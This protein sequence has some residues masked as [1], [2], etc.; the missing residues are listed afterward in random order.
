VALE[1]TYDQP[2]NR[3]RNP[4][5]QYIEAL[6]ARLHRAEA[7]LKTVLPDIDLND[8]NLDLTTPQ[9]ILP[10]FK[11][12][13]TA[14]AV[15]ASNPA[16]AKTNASTESGDELL[17]SMVDN[18]G[19]LDLDDQGHWDYH[20]QS[21]GVMFLRRM[22]EQ[23]GDLF[24]QE[25]Y[26]GTGSFLRPRPMS[27]FFDSPRSSDSPMESIASIHDLPTKEIA[28]ELCSNALDDACTLMRFVHQPSFYAMLDRIYDTPP[29]Q[30]TNEENR[31]LPLLYVV[32]ALGCLFAKTEQ[33]KLD[34]KDGYE[35]ATDQGLVKDAS[36]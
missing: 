11:R 15:G 14:P 4:A 28:K 16:A 26:R 27:Q 23:F 9:R 36:T 20:G 24:G 29:D 21:S 8:P 6:E 1:C 30:Y 5:P 35:G 25:L 10:T 32:M 31:F 2:S 22:R 7:L 12:N 3:R 34:L 17:E 19:S 13:T 33:S 18:T